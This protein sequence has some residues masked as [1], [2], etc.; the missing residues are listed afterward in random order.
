[1]ADIQELENLAR[2]VRRNI[3]EMTYHAKT[4]GGHIGGA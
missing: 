2:A 4:G 3:I 1:M